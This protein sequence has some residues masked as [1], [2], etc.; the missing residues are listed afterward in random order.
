MMYDES[1]LKFMG[2]KSVGKHIQISDKAVFYNTG[3]ISIGDYSRIDDFA[4]LS[5]GEGGIEIGRYVHIACFCTIIG[6]AKVILN[7]FSGISGRVSIYSSS[8]KY[9]GEWMTNPCLPKEVLNTYHEEVYLGKH[10]VVGSG[11]I[12]LPGVYL[13]N[14]CAIGAMSLVPKMKYFP[15]SILAGIPVKLI[16]RRSMKMYSLEKTLNL[17]N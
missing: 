9:D 8:D 16:G 4:I 10:V 7:D 5:A 17:E 6:K 1:H 2:F 14:G 11:T 13:D 12:L 3:N 15:E